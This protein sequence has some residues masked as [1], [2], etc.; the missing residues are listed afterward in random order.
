MFIIPIINWILGMQEQYRLLKGA[1]LSRGW[2]VKLFFDMSLENFAF[3]FSMLSCSYR[4]MRC[5]L[6]IKELLWKISKLLM[7]TL[8]ISL[9]LAACGGNSTRRRQIINKV[10]FWLQH[11]KLAALDKCWLWWCAKL[12][13]IGGTNF[14]GGL[15]RVIKDNKGWIEWLQKS[16]LWRSEVLFAFI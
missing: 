10:C 12:D 6:P 2:R 16:Q 5:I 13:Y 4:E 9:G 8:L 1:I 11:L 7:T 14:W 15:Y 3:L